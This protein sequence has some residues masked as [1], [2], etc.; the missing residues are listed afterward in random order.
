MCNLKSKNYDTRKRI[1][2]SYY[3]NPIR[4][5]LVIMKNVILF[6]KDGIITPY[7]NFRKCCLVND[8]P[9]WKLTKKKFP[10]FMENIRI[11]KHSVL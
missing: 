3:N 2:R 4:N 8:L 10:I 7:S 9:Y 11:E 1:Q 6:I 5:Y